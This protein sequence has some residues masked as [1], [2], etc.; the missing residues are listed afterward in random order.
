[1]SKKS[2]SDI[3]KSIPSKHEQKGKRSSMNHSLHRCWFPCKA[4]LSAGG[5]WASSSLPLLRGL[6]CSA[7]SAGAFALPSNQQ[8]EATKHMK[9]TFTIPMKKSERIW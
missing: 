1:M 3:S 2:N 7:F 4:S 8:L 9:A 5:R 6:I